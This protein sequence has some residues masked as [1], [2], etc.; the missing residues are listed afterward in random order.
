METQPAREAPR[1]RRSKLFA[2]KMYDDT[3]PS[4]DR[5][6]LAPISPRGNTGAEANWL[7]SVTSAFVWP[8]SCATPLPGTPL[9]C[10]QDR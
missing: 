4:G 9:S 6:D 10:A 2:D 7:I 5:R 1:C 8:I 3:W